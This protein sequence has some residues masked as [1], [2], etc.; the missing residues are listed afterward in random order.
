MKIK[1]DFVTNSSSTSYVVCMPRDFIIT[2]K[3]VEEDAYDYN[4]LIKDYEDD[5]IANP[6]ESCLK[7]LNDAV[8]H[9]RE[10]GRIFQDHVDAISSYTHYNI[11]ATTL[12]EAGYVIDSF[13][14][15]PD[16]GIIINVLGDDHYETVMNALIDRTLKTYKVKGEKDVTSEN[17][18]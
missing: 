4:Y 14:T 17:Q 2:E 15:G 16:S 10:K 11:V 6:E 13:D 18:K 9:L 7:N 8:Q 1:T 5:G 12:R 3:M